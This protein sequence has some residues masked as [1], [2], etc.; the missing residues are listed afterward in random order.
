MIKKFSFPKLKLK[1]L[2]R[3]KLEE[4]IDKETSFGRVGLTNLGNTCFMNSALQCLSHCE[5]LTKYFLLKYHLK[6]INS[7]NKYGSLGQVASGYYEL[8]TNLWMGNSKYISPNDFRIN[9]VKII[10]RFQGFSQQDSHELLTYLLDT[11]HEDLNRVTDKPYIELKD[12]ALEENDEEAS[13]RWWQN[14]LRR[15]NSI[16][17][18]LFHGQFKSTIKCP[19]CKKI[20]ITYDPFM[21]LG[22]P[23]ANNKGNY[24][25]KYFPNFFRNLTH[26]FHEIEL[27]ASF[28]NMQT[29]RDIKNE[30]HSI[31]GEKKN[32]KLLIKSPLSNICY[33]A[34]LV[35]KEKTFIRSLSDDCEIVEFLKDENEV[36]FYEKFGCNEQI[37]NYLD[38]KTFIF[39]P[40]CF[41]EEFYFY[42]FKKHKKVNLF[43]PL[44]ITISLSSK[45][46]D[47]YYLLF[48]AYRKIIPDEEK[49]ISKD[50]LDLSEE[51]KDNQDKNTDDNKVLIKT[52]KEKFF[53]NFSLGEEN[54][55]KYLIKEF[56]SYFNLNVDYTFKPDE[57]PF[58]LFFYNGNGSGNDLINNAYSINSF[59]AYIPFF[60]NNV[61]EFCKQKSCEFCSV[62]SYSKIN[63]NI[64]NIFSFNNKLQSFLVK[65]KKFDK[66]E[67]IKDQKEIKGFN[68]FF[69]K[70]KDIK[71][72]LEGSSEELLGNLKKN[73]KKSNKT[74]ENKDNSLSIYDCFDQFKKEEKLE[75]E[76]TWYCNVCKNQQEALK[77]MEIYRA[78]RILIIQLKRFKLKSQNSLSEELINGKNETLVNYPIENLDLRDYIVGENKENAIYS[79]FAISQH[80]GTL[81][82]GHY[83]TFCKNRDK[84]IEIDDENITNA[85]EKDLVNNFSYLLF[86]KMKDSY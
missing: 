26:E 49:V 47:L 15:E 12:Q 39:N 18:D 21:Y 37:K 29:I 74:L 55:E 64:S 30:I 71:F 80:F 79:M 40:V 63:K 70:N 33:E 56:K 27:C 44:L 67:D 42:F 35:D 14:H 77:K 51:E 81:S 84:W 41:K 16:I 76:N 9:L 8:I 72:P 75:R 86:Y 50:L 85:E 82:Q 34:V 38:Y 46:F 20:S 19:Q 58:E 17:V 78:P 69:C 57:V 11:L 6:D 28:V 22:L 61:C 68:N 31:Y 45:I 54:N 59:K 83:T 10:K 73:S 2:Q 5:D 32:G 65:F 52:N 60:N 24:Y 3:S 43:Y 7:R 62:N 53:E 13:N 4:I 23:I 66:D 1:E 48:L 36:I 25:V